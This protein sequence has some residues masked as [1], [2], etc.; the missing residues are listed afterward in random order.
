MSNQQTQTDRKL[1]TAKKKN[2][3]KKAKEI[4]GSHQAQ[5]IQN[6]SK[7]LSNVDLDFWP[8]AKGHENHAPTRF[9]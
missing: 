3:L 6:N 8:A 2:K 4:Q 5:E 9:P 7:A 1:K